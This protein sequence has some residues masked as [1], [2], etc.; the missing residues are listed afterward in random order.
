M[1]EGLTGA[2]AEAFIDEWEADLNAK[3][4]ADTRRIMED[5]GYT[6]EEI[7]NLIED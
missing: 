7:S 2:E 5:I 1:K 3:A 4:D 6:E